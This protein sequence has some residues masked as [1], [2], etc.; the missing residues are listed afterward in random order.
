[1]SEHGVPL[2]VH[3]EALKHA[4]D[5]V[6]DVFDREKVFIEQTLKPLS[7]R[8]PDL[9]IVF[10]HITTDD[11]VRF[12]K[13]ARDMYER[14]EI[15]KGGIRPHL[16]CLPV[17][18]RKRHM[19]SLIEAAT[20]GNPRFFLGTDSAPHS[21]SAKENACGC[22][23]IY[24]AHAGIELYAKVFEKEHAL[25]KLEGFASKFGADFYGLAY[26]E[27]SITLSKEDW[28]VPTHYP[29]AD[30]VIVPLLADETMS[31]KLV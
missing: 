21:K 9:K 29:F 20:S 22:A 8:F 1:M 16:Y 14:N 12:V 19:L 31:W 18:K 28:T 10:E 11:A 2:L 7:E 5:E 3:G 27:K 26:N 15:F 30:E 13:S 25:D 23:G 4:D 17:L 6:V 24:S